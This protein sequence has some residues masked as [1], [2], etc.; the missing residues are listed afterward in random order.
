MSYLTLGDLSSDI[1]TGIEQGLVQG[2][3]AD[4]TA[5][6]NFLLP[7]VGAA[8]LGPAGQILGQAVSNVA[9]P[10]LRDVTA[11]LVQG[12]APTGEMATVI[13]VS[14]QRL[15]PVKQAATVSIVESQAH[16]QQLLG[17]Q[18]SQQQQIAAQSAQS[19]LTAKQSL[20]KYAIYAGIGVAATLILSRLLRSR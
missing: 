14:Q 20:E 10:I 1:T 19:A 7:G 4:V 16:E 15:A 12:K 6:T 8:V 18:T 9:N 2:T 17:V 13:A 3:V 11:P 5:L